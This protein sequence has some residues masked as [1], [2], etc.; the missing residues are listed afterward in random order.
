VKP[1]TLLCLH[2]MTQVPIDTTVVV[3]THIRTKREYRVCVV[4]FV[5]C[6]DDNDTR[7]AIKASNG[8]VV[9]DVVA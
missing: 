9:E 3:G 8:R 7:K 6:D 5:T 1:E 2:C 4:C